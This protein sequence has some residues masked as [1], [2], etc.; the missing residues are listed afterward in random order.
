[1]H[2]LRRPLRALLALRPARA[3]LGWP[4]AL[5]LLVIAIAPGGLVLPICYGLYGA[6]RASFTGRTAEPAVMS[7]P[8]EDSGES[9]SA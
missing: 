4:R 8:L 6:L 9:R 7:A 3:A 5:V 2:T 1:M